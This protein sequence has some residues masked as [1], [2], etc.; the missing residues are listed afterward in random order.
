MP[1]DFPSRRQ[2]SPD[3]GRSTLRAVI[4]NLRLRLLGW[5]IEQALEL[6]IYQF[7][8]YPLP[9]SGVV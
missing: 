8:G 5:R 7:D 6:T 9:I 2:R 4:V 1:T 3:Y